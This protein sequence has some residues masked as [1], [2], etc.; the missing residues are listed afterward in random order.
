MGFQ[1]CRVQGHQIR[2][3]AGRQF[4]GDDLS[5]PSFHLKRQVS[6][7]RTE[8]ENPTAAEIGSSQVIAFPTPEVPKAV[9]QTI[10]LREGVVERAF[11]RRNS[12]VSLH[13]EL[14]ELRVQLSRVLSLHHF[15]RLIQGDKLLR[16]HCADRIEEGTGENKLGGL[17]PRFIRE[18]R[19]GM[20]VGDTV[21]QGRVGD[22][23]FQ[24]PG[25]QAGGTAPDNL[26]DERPEA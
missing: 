9:V 12:G 25:P 5:A 17:W 8:L 16:A 18:R 22:T 14:L 10:I 24:A 13:Q 11:L 1:V 26:G 2:G 23:V 6:A 19:S 20:R 3:M 7:G 15:G 4:E 21:L